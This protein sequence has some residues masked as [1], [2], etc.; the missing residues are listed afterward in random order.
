MWARK[1]IL[2]FLLNL[3]ILG[4]KKENKSHCCVVF[5]ITSQSVIKLN[6]KFIIGWQI[7]GGL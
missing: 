4:T 3:F 7:L 6:V 1:F 2:T 5:Q